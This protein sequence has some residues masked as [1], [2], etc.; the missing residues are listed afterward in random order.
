MRGRHW[1]VLS[2]LAVVLAVSIA[3]LFGRTAADETPGHAA[4]KASE[5]P[6]SAVPESHDRAPLYDRTLKCDLLDRLNRPPELVVLGGSR[7]MRFEPS[8][9]RQLTGLS[10]FNFAV[11][12]NRPEDAWAI[13]NYVVSRAPGV[14]LRVLYALQTT[15]LGD[16]NLHS[17]LLDDQ[18]FSQWFSPELVRSQKAQ[19]GDAEE[20]DIPD[21]NRY[22][23]RGYLLYNG[24]DQRLAQGVSQRWTLRNYIDRLLPGI[25]RPKANQGRSRRYFRKLLELCNDHDVIPGIVIMPYHPMVLKA[26]RAAGW[27][28]QHDDL[29]GYLHGLQMTYD[30][31]ILDYTDIESFAG[32]ARF[33]YDGAHLMGENS[34]RLLEQ[35]V[36]D[37]PESF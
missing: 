23:A 27:Q 9:V 7:A 25:S 13:W 18:R 35:A 19:N 31:R 1:Q 17:A 34:R 33:F 21:V 12:N 30:F 37:A 6:G 11:R 24:Y 5:T 28:A 2:A 3:V 36:K 16:T 22:T 10:A 26:F 20:A 32:V 29:L 15:A 14:K 8:Y 4:A